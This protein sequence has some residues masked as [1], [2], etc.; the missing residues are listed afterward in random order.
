LLPVA[1][2]LI[3][4]ALATPVDINKDIDGQGVVSIHAHVDHNIV[5]DV[6]DSQAIHAATRNLE[7]VKDKVKNML[8]RWPSNPQGGVAGTTNVNGS[9]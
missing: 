3:N 1:L 4:I 2:L 7:S 9:P 5:P 6:S 8:D